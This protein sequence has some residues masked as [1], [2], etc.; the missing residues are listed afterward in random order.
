MSINPQVTKKANSLA[1]CEAEVGEVVSMMP[2]QNA[3]TAAFQMSE[4]AISD[5][6]L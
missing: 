5:F 4:L 6:A 3:D 2:K 1:R